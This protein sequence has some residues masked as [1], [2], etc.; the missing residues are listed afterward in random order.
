M[1]ATVTEGR[2]SGAGNQGQQPSAGDVRITVTYPPAIKPYKA[3]VAETT[4]I[5]EVKSAVL[6]A[7]GLQE[8]ST[9]KFKLF[10][11]KTELSNLN[12]TVGQVAAGHKELALRLE[13][14]IVQG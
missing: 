11:G 2:A 9:K 1:I 12:Q 8:T 13:E 6:N 7:F 14:V 3:E 4:T 10:H 5:G